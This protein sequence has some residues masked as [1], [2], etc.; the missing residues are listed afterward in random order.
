MAWTLL[1]PTTSQPTWNTTDILVL[2]IVQYVL[3]E[4]GNGID[5]DGVNLL[6][7]QFT[8]AQLLDALNSNL[9]RAATLAMPVYLRASQGTL[10]GPGNLR[11]PLPASP[12]GLTGSG[13]APVC[14]AIREAAWLQDSGVAIESLVRTDSFQLDHGFPGWDE[15]VGTPFAYNDGSDLPNLTIEIA[16]NSP[17]SGTLSILYVPQPIQVLGNGSVPMNL[18]LPD[19]LTPALVY[20][21][22]ADVFNTAGDGKDEARATYCSQLSDIFIDLFNTATTGSPNAGPNLVPREQQ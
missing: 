3:L 13:A 16:P 4:N 15:T 7:T 18:S 8:Q 9:S 10:A 21:T 6:T 19:E 17:S 20:G 11:Y 5:A 22:L 2:Q 14:L 1:T 12:G